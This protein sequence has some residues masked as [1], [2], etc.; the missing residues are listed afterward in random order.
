VPKHHAVSSDETSSLRE[1]ARSTFATTRWSLVALAQDGISPAAHTA[2]EALCTAYWYPLYA[3]VRRKGLSPSD[4]QDLTQEFF[5]RLIDKNYLGSVD[6]KLGSFRSF[7]LASISHL[8]N[9]EWHK[10]RALKRGGER[11]IL[12]LDAEQAEGRFIQEADS[13]DS[14]EKAFDRRW[15]VTLLE[16]AL[17]R[18]R[19]EFST[20]GKLQQF[21][22]L[23][24]FLSELPE[25][26]DYAAVAEQ[27]GMD[28]RSVA[29]AVHRLRVRYREIVRSDVAETVTS[30]A[31]L[32]AEM[33]HL[34]ASLS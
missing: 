1:S 15:A 34:F 5:Y 7:L 11:Q 2:L 29:V 21:N 14:P 24:G 28:A 3:Y 8:L 32:K 10:A 27:L 6:R 18:L 12:S 16:R 25:Q 20:S 23:K 26:G 31:E 17:A 33:T 4:A 9:N 30:E 22:L 19:E 13:S